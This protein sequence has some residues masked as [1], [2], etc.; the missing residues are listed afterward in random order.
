M[1]LVKLPVAVLAILSMTLTSSAVV[2]VDTFWQADTGNWSNVSNWSNGE[3]FYPDYYSKCN[4]NINNGGTIQVTEND[5]ACYRLY[6]GKGDSSS[7]G[8]LGT[9]KEPRVAVYIIVIIINKLKYDFWHPVCLR[10]WH[11][12][13][14]TT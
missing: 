4:A 1:K 13:R 8:H 12:C 7:I 14:K 10:V 11:N 3:P 5:E 2:Y 6:L 9:L